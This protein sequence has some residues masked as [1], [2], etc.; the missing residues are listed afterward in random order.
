M[1]K[2]NYLILSL[3]GIFTLIGCCNYDDDPAPAPNG[4]Y[5]TVPCG[6]PTANL[7]SPS[8][9]L[10]E[11]Q[12]YLQNFH[13]LLNEYLNQQYPGNTGAG[14]DIWFD[15]DALKQYIHYI[16]DYADA[17]GYDKL[18]LRV[19]IGAK[20]VM[21]NNGQN[22]PAQ[23][24]FFVPTTGI[25]NEGGETENVNITEASRMNFGS[26]GIPDSETPTSIVGVP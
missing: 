2:S 21:G 7:I 26:A 1:K 15:L 19:Y 18:G 23:T 20:E 11:E 13:P 6:L 4:C 22:Y 12:L 17:K 8:A 9:A 25:A 14:R 3:I 5:V 10:A 16:E 24:V